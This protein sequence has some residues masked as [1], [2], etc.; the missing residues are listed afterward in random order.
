MTAKI[1][2]YE[3][4]SLGCGMYV[5]RHGILKFLIFLHKNHMPAIRFYILYFFLDLPFVFDFQPGEILKHT[6]DLRS[7][8]KEC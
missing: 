8:R 2:S 3:Y 4:R 1:N 6:V 7:G 5:E